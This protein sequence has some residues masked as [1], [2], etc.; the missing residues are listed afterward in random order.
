MPTTSSKTIFFPTSKRSSLFLFIKISIIPVKSSTFKS[1]FPFLV[2]F[3]LTIV[4]GA[5]I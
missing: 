1:I 5:K 3:V 2:K 4:K